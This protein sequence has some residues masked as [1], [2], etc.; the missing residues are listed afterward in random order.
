MSLIETIIKQL[1]KEIADL[2]KVRRNLVG[3]TK[4][5]TAKKVGYIKARKNTARKKLK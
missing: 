2:Q 5:S 4:A 1:D 3:L